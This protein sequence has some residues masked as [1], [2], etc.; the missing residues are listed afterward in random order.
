MADV[1]T[2]AEREAEYDA[3]V[4]AHLRRNFVGHFVHGMLGLTGFRL[5][6]APT[7]IPTYI[8]RLTGSDAL[9]GL[10]T[11][12]LQLGAIVSPILSAS[13][14]ETQP[15][16]LPY[17]IRT[18]TM[19]RVCILGL[20]MSGWLLSGHA[21]LFATLACFFLLGT[22]N[23]IQ[24]V[25]FQ[26]LMAK[27]IPMNRRGRLQAWRNMA[28]GLIAAGLSYVAGRWLI[29]GRPGLEG[30]ADTFFLAFVLTSLGLTA[31]RFIMVE[32]VPAT[33]RAPMRFADR[34]KTF[35][36]LLADRD[37]RWFILAEALC[38]CARIAGP[39]YIL[40]AGQQIG[41]SGRVIGELSLAYL[42]ADTLSNLLWGHIGDRTGY[43][44]TFLGSTGLWAAAVALLLLVH[45]PW[46]I[47]VAF[48]GLGAGASGYQM[49]QQTM[50]LEFGERADVA[51]R[52]AL[53]TTIEGA[54]STVGPLLG[55]IVA[56]TLGYPVLMTASLLF[57]AGS[58]VL[59]LFKVTEPRRRTTPWLD[60]SNAV[61]DTG[62]GSSP[63][64]T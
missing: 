46:A 57:L 9:V 1:A 25:A 61:S 17:A 19:M 50:V 2:L 53:S 31:L 11:S 14:F 56:T 10:G 58:F 37:Y 30:Y 23:G 44:A 47:F 7:F 51:M 60:D 27:V 6:Y 41:L 38:V 18:G 59:I 42:G 40:Y 45:Q 13:R 21:L 24:R 35:P 33:L 8:H 48:C 49:S 54:I 5:I 28:G 4:A 29:G 34:I 12:L 16:I 20:A 64:C 63:R 26:M 15:R 22:F 55:G 62:D 52:L 43:R 32:P 39:F 36:T 3:F